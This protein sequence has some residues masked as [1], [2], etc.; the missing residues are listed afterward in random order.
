MS[1]FADILDTILV[2]GLEGSGM[3]LLLVIS[4]KI[5]RM[6]IKTHSNCCGGNVDVSTFNEGGS[7]EE[8]VEQV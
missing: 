2:S 6:R 5:Y 7:H 8:A 1:E 3:I 4:Y